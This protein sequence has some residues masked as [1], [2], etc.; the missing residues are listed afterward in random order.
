MLSI[1]L[2]WLGLSHKG[3]CIVQRIH[4]HIYK[5]IT[6]TEH[7]INVLSCPLLLRCCTTNMLVLFETNLRF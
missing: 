5:L 3:V 2:K 6:S 1:K 7:V 4:T